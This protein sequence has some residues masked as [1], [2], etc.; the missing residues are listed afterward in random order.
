VGQLILI[1]L[2]L[3]GLLGA[4]LAV[5]FGYAMA[6]YLVGRL[7]RAWFQVTSHLTWFAILLPTLPLLALLPLSA[8]APIR[9]VVKAPLAEAIQQRRYG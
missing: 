5:P 6:V 4:V 3:L 8:L 2:G 1:E 9:S 7:S